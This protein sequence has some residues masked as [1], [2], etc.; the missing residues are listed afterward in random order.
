VKNFVDGPAEEYGTGRDL[1]AVEGTSRLSP[2][3]FASARS[4]VSDLARDPWALSAPGTS[5]RRHLSIR[6]RLASS[7]GSCLQEPGART[8]NYSPEFD[9]FEWQTPS[10][11]ELESWQQGRTGYPLVDAGMR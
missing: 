8:R 2:R 1:P 9:R 3:I 7:V 4:A 6:A 10:D 11:A 5:R